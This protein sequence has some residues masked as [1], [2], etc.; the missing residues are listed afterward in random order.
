MNGG[1]WP[2]DKTHVVLTSCMLLARC[3]LPTTDR[4]VVGQLVELMKRKL[5][6]IM[7][8]VFGALSIWAVPK[9]DVFFAFF[10]DLISSK[11]I[12]NGRC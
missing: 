3:R 9:T 4:A 6:I 12:N 11:I 10:R 2:G 5:M 7:H 1:P 8:L